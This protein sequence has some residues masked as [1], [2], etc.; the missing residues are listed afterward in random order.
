VDGP[1]SVT[2]APEPLERANSSRRLGSR[3]KL[4]AAALLIAALALRIGEVQ[5][6]AYV[7]VNDAGSYLALASQIAHTGD[8]SN[9]H[10]PGKGAGGTRGPS[11]YFPP[12][13]PYFL[14]AVDLIDG[15]ATTRGAAV[16]PARLSQALLGTVTVGLIGLVALEAFGATT[17]LIAL[18]L[19]AFYPVL[20][21]LAGTIV[22]ENLLV[23]FEL[24]AV[25]A[26]L[27]A[28]R[29]R[30]PYAWIAG[31]GVFT[32]LATLT[33]DNGIVLLI[34]LVFAVWSGRPRFTPRALAAPALLVACVVLTLA[35][36][37][38]RNAIVMH[39]F[40]PV[41]DE[42][43][44]TL[45]GTYNPASA[46]NH[47]IP[48]KWRLFYGIPQDKGLIREVRSMTEPALGDRLQSQAF[49]YIGAHP[50][51]PVEVAYHNTL[52]LLE[53]EGSVAWHRSAT[54]MDIHEETARV[55]V[56]SF[57]IM[58]LLALAGAFTRL[59]RRAPRWVWAV[60]ILFAL[61]VVLVNVETPRFREP[62]EPFLVLLAACAV[63]TALAR[64]RG[65]SPVGRERDAS[66]PAGGGERVEVIERLP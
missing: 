37:L 23:V 58:C 59:A 30:R 55:G 26:A 28:R 50:L 46:A 52:R 17:A 54:A 13:Y 42:T 19:A 64:L 3:Q 41:S 25:W 43:G 34:P 31:T 20:I 36:W 49:D 32:G 24:A 16:H 18:A 44:I 21:E 14:A 7:P 33:H 40:I 39:Q 53:L 15:H 29:S 56:D 35:P 4:I 12:G 48:Y 38:I 6:A 47:V 66:S 62:V 57:W 22:A 27:R 5:R 1:S 60:P 9:S 45:V 65:G 51:A 63:T 2:S 61:T 11:A 10:V 8:Y